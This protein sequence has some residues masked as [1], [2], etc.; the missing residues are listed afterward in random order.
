M[1]RRG[2]LRLLVVALILGGGAALAVLKVP[3][4]REQARTHWRAWRCPAL[5]PV[6][7]TFA[8]DGTPSDPWPVTGNGPSLHAELAGTPDTAFVDGYGPALVRR[9]GDVTDSLVAIAFGVDLR[10]ADP[11]PDLRLCL[12]IDAADGTNRA[13]NAK[14]LR[15][16][17]HVP[18][19]VERFNFEWILRDL[20]V[21]PDDRVSAFVHQRSGRAAS[22]H[23]VDLVFRSAAPLTPR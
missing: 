11:D 22:L 6:H 13:W 23:R 21:H 12:R 17:E 2:I 16:D 3:A 8:P 18:G 9:I 14:Q 20:A 5:P 19:A 7:T 15:S 1:T 10:C 4:L